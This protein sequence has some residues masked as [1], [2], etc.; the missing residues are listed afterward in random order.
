M[1]H[2]LTSN[3][4]IYQIIITNYSRVSIY[5]SIN[6]HTVFHTYIYIHLY[7][8]YLHVYSNIHTYIYTYIR[9]SQDWAC[10]CERWR[11]TS[12]SSPSLAPRNN[13]TA[14]E[15]PLL[16]TP[17]PCS[18]GSSAGYARMFPVCMYVCMYVMYILMYSIL[19]VCIH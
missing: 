11:W 9:I 19:Y 12:L 6:I 14:V 3:I 10:S 5:I 16:P 2:Q 18:C 1:I 15:Q 4:Y 7:I 17:S 13:W 8:Q